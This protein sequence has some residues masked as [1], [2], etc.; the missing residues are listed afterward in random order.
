MEDVSQRRLFC[1]R[2]AVK[3]QTSFYVALRVTQFS[4]D[5]TSLKP[6]S[7]HVTCVI[8]GTLET[9]DISLSQVLSSNAWCNMK[10]T[11][12][13]RGMEAKQIFQNQSKKKKNSLQKIINKTGKT[14]FPPSE[15]I[16]N[17]FKTKY[18]PAGR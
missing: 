13:G 18:F 7:R 15:C 1:M 17:R 14:C 4:R 12:N 16:C 11:G 10:T 3:R 5:S 8:K 9:K 6:D 2:H